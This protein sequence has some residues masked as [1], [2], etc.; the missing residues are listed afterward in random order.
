MIYSTNKCINWIGIQIV[1]KDFV[2]AIFFIF[3]VY[4][5]LGLCFPILGEVYQTFRRKWQLQELFGMEM[6]ITLRNIMPL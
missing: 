5:L 2:K 4:D 1:V 3:V 6:G